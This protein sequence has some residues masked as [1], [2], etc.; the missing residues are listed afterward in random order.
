MR[1]LLLIFALLSYG[2]VRAQRSLDIAFC[3]VESLYDTVPSKF[4]DDSDYTPQGRLRWDSQR[5][6]RKVESVARLIDS[7]AVPVVTLWG[8]ENEQ[9]VRDVVM[10]TERNYILENQYHVSDFECLEI[11]MPVL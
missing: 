2:G 11:S 1:W 5:Y 3:D 7:L 10:A 9:V 8:V 4:Y 6:R